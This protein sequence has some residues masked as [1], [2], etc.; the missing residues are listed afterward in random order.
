MIINCSLFPINAIIISFLLTQ[1]KNEIIFAFMDKIKK[2]INKAV[3]K[4]LHPIAHI[5]LR[6]EISHSELSEMTRRAYVD[7]AFKYFSIPNRKQTISRASVITGLSRTEVARIAALEDDLADIHSTPNRA[8]RVIGG[9]LS[10]SDYL[11]EEN[12]PKVLPLRDA[13]I[14]F[15]TLVTRYSGGI[16]AR[17][18]LDEMIRT[19]AVDKVDKEHVKLIH[20][21][22]VPHG[23]D[24]EKINIFLTHASDLLDTG[25]HNLTQIDQAPRFQRQVTYVDMPESVVKQFEK[26][27]HDMSAELL[28]KLNQWL[29]EESKKID[30]ESEEPKYRIGLGIYYFKNEKQGD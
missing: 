7:A 19:G 15:E 25:I 21:G 4:L 17:A 12:E 20:H 6:Y 23:D 3:L 29:S 2:T 11:D 10:D 16:T 5:L 26:L 30:P 13:D 24:A 1:L 27:S 8:T 22:F 9:W 18:I 28:V 14:S